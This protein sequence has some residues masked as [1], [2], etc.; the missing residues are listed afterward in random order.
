M[1]GLIER[2]PHA[3]QVAHSSPNGDEPPDK[4]FIVRALDL[5][6]GMT[7]GMGEGISPLIQQT[8][9]RL[10]TCLLAC[11][12]DMPPDVACGSAYACRLGEGVC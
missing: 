2:T 10:Q 7:E 8:S 4:E 3:E 6:S 12:R 5:I 9:P 1:V 11:M